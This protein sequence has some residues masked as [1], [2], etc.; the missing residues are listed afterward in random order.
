M[1]KRDSAKNNNLESTHAMKTMQVTRVNSFM[2]REKEDRRASVN[3]ESLIM[4]D[5]KF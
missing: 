3:K 4:E 1:S 2:G 5:H